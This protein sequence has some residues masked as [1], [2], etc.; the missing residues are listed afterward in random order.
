MVY[1]LG[2]TSNRN[3]AG[4]IPPLVAVVEDAIEITTQDFCVYEG[5][6]REARQKQLVAQGYS[7]TLESK[8]LRQ[9]D[10]FGHA[11][12]LVPWIQGHPVWDWDGCE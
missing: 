11:T 9:L 7:K 10:G 8:H 5:L 2:P 3:L 4:V 6:R 1:V 12:D